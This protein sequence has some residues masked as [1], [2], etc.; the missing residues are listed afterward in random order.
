MIQCQNPPTSHIERV[1]PAMALAEE[2]CRDRGTKLTQVRRRILELL[3]EEY[4]PLGAYDLMERLRQ[5]MKRPFSP[6]TIYRALEFLLAHRLIARIE[7]R[8]AFV[9][10]AH[11][12]RDCDCIFLSCDQC[13][14]VL[15]IPC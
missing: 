6:P 5:T 15:Q 12:Q 1:E 8:N 11:A 14:A 10:R 3:A 13:G 2:I 9:L 7:S 4:R